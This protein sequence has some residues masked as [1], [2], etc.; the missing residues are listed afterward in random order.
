MAEFNPKA[1]RAKRP[2]PIWVDAF[3]RDTQ[4]LEADEVGGYFLILMAMWTREACDFPNDPKRLARVCRV[5][6][7]LWNSRVGPALMTFFQVHDGSVISKRLRKEATYVERQV[8][9]QSDRKTGEKSDKPLES[10]D[11]WL[12]ADITTD[13][14]TDVSAA[15]S[16]PT[17]QHIDDD[18]DRRG[19]VLDHADPPEVSTVRE[20][21]LAAMGVDP[22]G[23]TGP[24]GR[25]IGRTADM[26]VYRQWINDLDLT[27]QQVVTIIG[28]VMAQKRTGADPGPPSTFSYFTKPMQE[29]AATKARPALIPIQGGQPDDHKRSRTGTGQS[30]NPDPKA[31]ALA[32]VVG[33][34]QRAIDQE[35]DASE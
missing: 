14:S 16:I 23:L 25:I 20:Q 4:H 18:D 26:Q 9:L 22:T 7:R 21:V 1:S 5:S 8:T 30:R 13:G 2:C 29:A 33:A 35:H 19:R 31:R 27:H 6:T 32:G 15:P 17:T 28:E 24:N 11:P 3:Q 12:T 10:N 34:F